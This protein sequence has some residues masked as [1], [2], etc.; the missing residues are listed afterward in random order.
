MSKCAR[1]F[2]AFA[3][4]LFALWL[5]GQL[6]R[7]R[8]WL[9][10]PLFYV[11]SLL[12]GVGI[13]VVALLGWRVLRTRTLLLISLLALPPLLTAF[14]LDHHWHRPPRPAVDGP[15][16]EL[17]H[18]NLWYGKEALDE[19]RRDAAEDGADIYVL[20]EF[21]PG[22]AAPMPTTGKQAYTVVRSETFV[23]MAKGDFGLLC[24]Y[25][26]ADAKSCL[27]MWRYRGGMLCV[28]ALDLPSSLWHDRRDYLA[29][30]RMLIE[31]H[32][33]DIVVGDFNCPRRAW[34]LRDLP[35]GYAHAYDLAGRGWSH[36]WPA[37]CPLLSI[38]QCLV[39]DSIAPLDYRLRTS[40]NSDHRRQELTFVTEEAPPATSR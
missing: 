17:V 24:E 37:Y 39:R 34:G 13:L 14:F 16:L 28:L 23:I 18:W 20:S 38:D 32:R 25:S 36:T 35:P 40:W 30:V 19:I 4:P 5:V 26:F 1:V 15:P 9:L 8:V 31:L 3:V 7:E 27:A 2:T 33:P 29:W 6:V 11:P 12:W 10:A 21:C 22:W